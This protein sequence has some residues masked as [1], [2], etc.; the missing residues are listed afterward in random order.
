MLTYVLQSLCFPHISVFVARVPEIL[1]LCLKADLLSL[2]VT[3]DLNHNRHASKLSVAMSTVMQIYL[4][5]SFLSF[6]FDL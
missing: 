5:T 1:N 6:H 2:T 4:K 3:Q